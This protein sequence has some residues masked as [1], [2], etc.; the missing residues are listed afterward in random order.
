METDSGVV[1][2]A[3]ST[4]E[5]HSLENMNVNQ[6]DSDKKLQLNALSSL[7]KRITGLKSLEPLSGTKQKTE[8]ELPKGPKK[9]VVRKSMAITTHVKSLQ[10]IHNSAFLTKDNSA[11]NVGKNAFGVRMKPLGSVPNRKISKAVDKGREYYQK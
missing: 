2:A 6:K 3:S 9:L 11:S 5:S 7:Q 10:P 8:N 1:T 4:S